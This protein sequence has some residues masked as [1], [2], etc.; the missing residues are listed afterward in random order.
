M[1]GMEGR[2]L[3]HQPRKKWA[4]LVPWFSSALASTIATATNAERVSFFLTGL[5]AGAVWQLLNRR[6]LA[7]RLT[8]VA[9]L[10][11]VGVIANLAARR[12]FVWDDMD[13]VGLLA[14]GIFLG[15]VYTEHYQRWRER[16]ASKRQS[17]TRVSTTSQGPDPESSS[18]NSPPA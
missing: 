6:D 8:F 7:S 1:P 9:V 16:T 18:V 10:V 17:I 11:T 14:V 15:L 3:D 4:W 2:A 13:T 5:A 12:E